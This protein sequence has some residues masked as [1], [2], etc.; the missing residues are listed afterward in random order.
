MRV[1]GRGFGEELGGWGRVFGDG[2]EGEGVAVWVGVSGV[3]GRRVGGCQGRDVG[4]GRLGKRNSG[5]RVPRAVGKG[6][7]GKGWRVGG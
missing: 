6:E 7:T 3:A 1:I 5:V 2:S 4:Q